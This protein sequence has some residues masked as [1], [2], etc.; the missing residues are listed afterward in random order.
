LV[1]GAMLKAGDTLDLE[2]ED[3]EHAYLVPAIGRIT[4]GGLD[5]GAR[6]GVAIAEERRVTINA[7][8]DSEIVAVV[9]R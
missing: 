2:L 9:A 4:I 3:G 8:E 6:D 7:V 5:V 1:Q